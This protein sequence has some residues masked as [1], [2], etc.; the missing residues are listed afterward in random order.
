MKDEDAA[1]ERKTGGKEKEQT[2]K[3]VPVRIWIDREMDDQIERLVCDGG[4]ETKSDAIRGLI[5]SGLNYRAMPS[6]LLP[7][8]LQWRLLAL[9]AR[10]TGVLCYDQDGRYV[11][12]ESGVERLKNLL[13]KHIGGRSSLVVFVL[14]SVMALL[15]VLMCARAGACGN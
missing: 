7:A 2:G 1:T 10:G 9:L 11:V 6:P 14:V 3:T 13:N 5:K 4:Y 15:I 12:A 8:E